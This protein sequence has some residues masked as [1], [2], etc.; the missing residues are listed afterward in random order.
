M[1]QMLSS[2]SKQAHTELKK[3]QTAFTPLVEEALAA[4]RAKQALSE[5]PT[6]LSR[7]LTLMPDPGP[8]MRMFSIGGAIYIAL[9]LVLHRQGMSAAQVWTI[10]DAATRKRFT[11][12]SK[13]TKWLLSW[14]MFSPLWRM[15]TRRLAAQS[16]VAPVGGWVVEYLPAE[17]GQYDYGVTYRRCAIAQLAHDVGAQD[18]AP[19]ICQS[20]IIGSDA[21]GWGLARTKTIAQGDSHCDFRFRRGAATDVKVKL[22]VIS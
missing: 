20:D 13:L 6:E 9:Y 17:P 5:L 22:P 2:V 1:S 14:T 18:F 19:Y 16:K 10:C 4:S 8:Q 11:G 3:W 7:L 12:M 21:F 15:L